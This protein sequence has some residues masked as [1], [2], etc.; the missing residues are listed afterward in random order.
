M[1]QPHLARVTPSW[2]GD[3][4]GPY[5]GDTLVIDTVG[6]AR[7]AIEDFGGTAKGMKIEL[8]SAD[9]QNKPDIGSSIASSWFD[10]E[11]V[12]VIIDVPNS[13]IALAVSEIARQKNRLFLASGA[14]T[15][16]LTGSKCNANTLHW[17][18]DTW[19]LANSTGKAM[20]KSGGDTWFFI[21]ADYTFGYALEGDTSAVVQSNGGKVLGKVRHPLNTNDFSSFLLQ[22]QASKAKIRAGQCRRRYDQR[23]Q[24]GWRIRH[25]EGRAEACRPSVFCTVGIGHRS[26]I[27]PRSRVH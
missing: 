9:H 20:V 5:E 2:N 15:A 14:G 7:L 23:H 10:V 1:N 6:I 24:A 3:A 19:N 18:Y 16:E 4:V 21:T 11:K 27:S 8:I 22:A 25:H 13:G 12:D 26:A 17:T